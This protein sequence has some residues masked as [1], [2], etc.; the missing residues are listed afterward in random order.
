VDEIDNPYA[1]NTRDSA[2]LDSQVHRTWSPPAGRESDAT[3]A[4]QVKLI[5]E[6]PLV[7]SVIDALPNAVIIVNRHRQLIAAN[8]ALR[9]MLRSDTAEFAGKRP[10]ELIGCQH[11]EKG[12]DGCGTS[13]YCTTCGAVGAVLDSMLTGEQSQR[14]LRLRL[15]PPTCEARDLKVTANPIQVMGEQFTI[16][17]FEDISDR[18]R[19]AVLSRAFFHDVLNTVGVIQGYAG[20]LSGGRSD[21]KLT[22]EFL[23]RLAA[24]SQQLLEEIQTHRDLIYAESGDLAVEMVPVDVAGILTQLVESFSEHPCARDRHLKLVGVRPGT[25]MTDARLLSRVLVNMIKNALE[26]TEPGGTVTVGCQNGAGE[27]EFSVHNASA[28]PPEV[29]LQVFQR[30]FSTKGQSGRGI[31]THSMKLLGELYLGGRVFF[32][33]SETEGTTFSLA[34]PKNPPG[35]E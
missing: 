17:V 6:A 8:Q 27:I 16:C 3:I 25:V 22:R 10:G 11:V 2:P 29:Q 14:E 19:L 1:L 23:G 20:L 28:M 32:R 4:R 21:P 35:A 26:A 12:P 33:S 34:L 24:V 7:Q 13:V 30:S 15:G 31:G 18:K 9:S 5:A